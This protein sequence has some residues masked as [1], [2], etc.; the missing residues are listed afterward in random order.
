MIMI[1]AHKHDI[2]IINE[3]RDNSRET[4]RTCGF[5]NYSNA[6]FLEDNRH[7]YL[8]FYD[9]AH[10]EDLLAFGGLTYIQWENRLAEIS[11]IVNP[12]NRKDGKGSDCVDMLLDEAFNKMNLKTVTG[13]CYECNPGIKFWYRVIDKYDGYKTILKNRKFWDGKYHDSLYFS[14]DVSGFK[15]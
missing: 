8:S 15:A 13:E 10:K 9:K 14:I 4:L 5:S 3:W 2:P 6:D 1:G 7:R 12:S 11:L